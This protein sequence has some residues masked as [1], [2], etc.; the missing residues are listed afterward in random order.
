[1]KVSFTDYIGRKIAPNRLS[2]YSYALVQGDNIRHK[3]GTAGAGNYIGTWTLADNVFE[4]ISTGS[5]LQNIIDT[6]IEIN[7]NA[8]ETDTFTYTKFKFV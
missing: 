2:V 1:M 7:F 5:S 3:I 4:I 6:I 8:I